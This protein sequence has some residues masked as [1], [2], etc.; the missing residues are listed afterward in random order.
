MCW[1]RT[2]SWRALAAAALDQHPATVKFARVESAAG[3]APAM[4][5]AAWLGLR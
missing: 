4:L 2:T 1:A 3:N 5:L